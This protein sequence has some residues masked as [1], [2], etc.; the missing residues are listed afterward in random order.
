MQAGLYTYRLTATDTA[1]NIA[2]STI[3]TID[4]TIRKR[5]LLGT[6]GDDFFTLHGSDAYNVNGNRGNDTYLIKNN[7]TNNAVISDNWGTNN[8]FLDNGL[9]VVSATMSLGTLDL[10]LSNQNHVIING[11]SKFNYGVGSVA[12]L[13]IDSFIS[14]IGGGNFTNSGLGTPNIVQNS[15]NFAVQSI[16]NP[17]NGLVYLGTN[18]KT[19]ILGS[20][21]ADTYFFSKYQ[22]GETIINDVSGADIISIAADAGID[23]DFNNNNFKLVLN[24]SS[25]KINLRNDM[26]FMV[27][28][29][30]FTYQQFYENFNSAT[31]DAP[32]FNAPSVAFYTGQSITKISPNLLGV[33]DSDS[34]DNSVLISV[35]SVANGNF[36][37]EAGVSIGS[38]T[39]ADLIADKVFFAHVGNNEFNP[40]ISLTARDESPNANHLLTIT[41]NQQNFDLL[42]DANVKLQ[43]NFSGVFKELRFIRNQ[44]D[45]FSLQVKDN[46]NFSISDDGKLAVINPIDFEVNPETIS[47]TILVTN[48]N[49][50]DKLASQYQCR[51]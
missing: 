39:R 32:V 47:L 9:L 33:S 19:I 15:A 43:E 10:T 4:A 13:D 27:G 38:F 12:S 42:P 2:S 20:S 24:N 1:N 51:N 50:F 6:S 18:Q 46:T 17:E 44:S 22:T 34:F 41:I 23:F 11:A 25:F 3:I 36:V 35:A 49:N 16:Q 26:K 31:N 5:N 45:N 8:I 14:L 37:N 30:S 28:N 7:L 40:F 48:N 29:S 21:G